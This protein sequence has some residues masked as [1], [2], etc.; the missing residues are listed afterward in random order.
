M[1][2]VTI[3]PESIQLI[4]MTDAEYFSDTY[5]EYIS[6]SKLGLINPDEGGSPEQFLTGIKETFSESFE[7]GSAVHATVLQP[8]D[9]I[10]APIYKPTG[11]L[12]VFADKV[13]PLLKD[14][15]DFQLSIP[16][17]ILDQGSRKADYYAGKLSDKRVQT[18]LISCIPYW[19]KKRQ[20]ESLLENSALNKQ[21]Y[22]SEPIFE[23]Y[24][25]C[26][27]GIKSN[28]SIQEILYPQGVLSP[29]EFFNEYAILCDLQYVDEDTGEITILKFKAKLDNFTIDHETSII[30]LNDLKTTSKPVNFFMGNNVKSKD[31]QDNDIT[32]WY[33]GSFQ[34]YRYYRQMAVYVWILQN[35]MKHLYN[36]SYK[37]KVNMIVIETSPDFNNRIFPVNGTYI[38]EGLKEFKNLLNLV[39]ECQK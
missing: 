14:I 4:R 27:L 6:N 33:N 17:E 13:Y 25:Q 39:V 1:A 7:L 18:A 2:E 26:V 5:K 8:D 12:G 22:L 35:A 9:F 38:K 19:E 21:V 36:L 20:Y 29:A 34:K 15:G 32:V 16:G 23:K 24:K 31:E 3:I 37:V 10:I 28:P 11:K 30:T